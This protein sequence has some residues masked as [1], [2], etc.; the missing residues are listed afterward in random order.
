MISIEDIQKYLDTFHDY[1]IRQNH[2]CRY[3]DQKCT[4]DIVCFIADC[5][6]STNCANKSFT[7]NDLWDENYFITN[8]R[9]IFGKPS[10]SD[11]QTRN[12]YNKVLSQPLKLLAYAHALDVDKIDG[13]LHFKAKSVDLLEYI[14][15]KERY[16]FNFLLAF[17]TK[18]LKDSG[19]YRIFD[20]YESECKKDIRSAKATIYER[21]YKFVASN[22]LSH[23]KT[24]VD[25][26]FHK[27]FNVIAYSK[28][29]PGSRGKELNWYD[30]MYNRVNWR[31]LGK[32]KKNETRA[33]SVKA[34]KERVNQDFY[35]S[36]QV[37]KAIKMVRKMQG[38][39]SEVNDELAAGK[40]TEVHHI[41][42]R[43]QYPTIASMFENL[44]L[45]T[46]SQH[47][48]KAHP[49]GNTQAVSREYQLV[50][51]LAKSQTIEKYISTVNG[52]FYN[53]EDFIYV[54]NTGL[55]DDKIDNDSISFDGIRKY[56]VGYY[57]T[58]D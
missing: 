5:I 56:L 49:N 51:L 27:V 57:Q 35:I 1:D 44:I 47:H 34:E 40:A 9:V 41:F 45:L 36:Y 29:L 43:S 55:T 24:D 20:E 39:Q 3:V 46:S 23:S 19:I 2:D 14:S 54:I 22:T 26:M 12:E 13:V 28:N 25:R 17:F 16:A 7:V 42:P 37:T 15:T 10:P 50:C 8:C 33:E 32:K 6:L 18:V 52:G 58:H 4:P 48:Q 53:K 11:P 31:D 30:L 38:D 21:Y